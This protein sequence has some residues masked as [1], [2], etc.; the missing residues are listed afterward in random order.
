MTLTITDLLC[1]GCAHRVKYSSWDGRLMVVCSKGRDTPSFRFPMLDC[2][3]FQEAA[4]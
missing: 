2:D 4:E 1:N 3:S